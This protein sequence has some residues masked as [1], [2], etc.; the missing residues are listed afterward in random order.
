ML[1]FYVPDNGVQWDRDGSYNAYL[2]PVDRD[3][4]I[5]WEWDIP[6]PAGGISVDDVVVMAC[7]PPRSTLPQR[8]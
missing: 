6:S 4:D 7:V 2:P 3:W 1:Q 5:C 8:Y